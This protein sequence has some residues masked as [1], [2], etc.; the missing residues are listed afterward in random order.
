MSGRGGRPVSRRLDV[1]A[2]A[3]PSPAGGE[4]PS[5]T[6]A[7]PPPTSPISIAVTNDTLSFSVGL[8]Q[9]EMYLLRNLL[10]L[11]IPHL[12]GWQYQLMPSSFDPSI[13]LAS[14]GRGEGG[15]ES[16]SALETEEE[17]VVEQPQSLQQSQQPRFPNRGQQQEVSAYP[18]RGGPVRR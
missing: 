15:G 16:N 8:A 17:I 14:P 3:S 1:A 13:N 6:V 2:A 9:Q 10:G 12:T 4:K 18:T 5:S 11:S 7:R